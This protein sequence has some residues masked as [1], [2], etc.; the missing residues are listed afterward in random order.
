MA[1]KKTTAK[2]EP[3]AERVEVENPATKIEVA[4]QGVEPEESAAETTQ[5]E[6]TITDTEAVKNPAP[7][8]LDQD[9]DRVKDVVIDTLAE[10]VTSTDPMA[11]QVSD[12][13]DPMMALA[14][15]YAA[16][17][18]N[19]LAFH[20]TSDRQVFLSGDLSEAINHQR[21]LG[22]GEVRTIQF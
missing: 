16:Y 6:I 4:D 12:P 13:T 2:A 20:I 14:M 3:A 17:Y 15:Q 1:T 19:N 21:T 7:E 22:E 9:I 10:V 8:E 18:P 11:S 5:V